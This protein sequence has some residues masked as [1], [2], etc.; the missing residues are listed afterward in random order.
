MT[1]PPSNFQ[2]QDVTRA[3]KAAAAVGVGIARMFATDKR[4]P[5]G[6]PFSTVGRLRE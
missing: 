2:Q 1:R 6:K 3:V 5:V 4:L